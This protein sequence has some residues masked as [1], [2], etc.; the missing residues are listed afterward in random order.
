MLER[1]IG[2]IRGRN[3]SSN[4]PQEFLAGTVRI[5]LCSHD[6][7]LQMLELSTLPSQEALHAEFAPGKMRLGRFRAAAGACTRT[8]LYFAIV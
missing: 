3:F 6:I 1:F 7:S 4:F 8:S 2:D 5:R